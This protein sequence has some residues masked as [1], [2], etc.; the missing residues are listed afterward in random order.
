MRQALAAGLIL[1]CCLNA[2]ASDLDGCQTGFTPAP[3]SY[4]FVESEA[5][6]PKVPAG[7]VIDE[8]HITRLEIFD[9]SNPRENNA[10]YRFGNRFHIL[11]RERTV[12][13]DL[14]FEPGEP[15]DVDVINESARLL[16]DRDHLY[17]ADVRP[18]SVCGDKVDVEVITRDVWS[19]T[20]ELSVNRSGGENSF[21]AGIAEGNL[22]GLGRQLS[23]VTEDNIDRRS[24]RFG[25]Q[26]ANIGGSRVNLKLEYTD[27][28]DGFQQFGTVGLPFYSLDTRRAWNL[29]YDKVKRDVEQFFRGNEVTAV[30]E[31]IEEAIA[32]IGFSKGLEKDV[33]RRWRFGWRWRE[34]NYL[35][36]P[37]LPPP[38][39][40]PEDRTFSYPW[41][42]YE[43]VEDNYTTS[44]NLDEI[45]RTED[46]H[47]GHTLTA[48]VGLAAKAFGS[49][50]DR[51]VTEV[52]LSDTLLFDQRN[53]LQHF[54]HL[55]TLFNV[56]QQ[57]AEDV[58]ASYTLRYFRSRNEHRSFFASFNAVFSHD[59]NSQRQITLGGITGARAFDNRF[60]AG[61]R[62]LQVSLEERQYTDLHILNLVRVG[63]AAFLDV[64]RAWEPGTDD[65]LEDGL[66]ANVGFG[67]RL[68]SS[69]ADVGRIVHIDFAT[70]LTNRDDPDVDSL[71]ISVNIKNSF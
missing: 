59:R 37:D 19:F 68:A 27:S 54:V 40:F 45:H 15:Y 25:Y 47:L 39:L 5:R 31:E 67:I 29:T 14:L 58:L 44:F 60:Q 1:T 50:A 70:P 3:G 43:S 38:A 7:A 41:L 55:E 62:R 48:R 26:D 35:P 33:T 53:L 18:V 30:R 49:S 46:L 56:D 36:S 13:N 16:R 51:V 24:T 65:G 42:E 4:R 63:Y 6:E 17:D 52:R 21:R 34:E 10:V 69:K 57:D 12:R 28:D 20:P 22:L 32:S 2:T 11:T 64:G 71:Q 9:E 66:L 61:D 23:F 8:V